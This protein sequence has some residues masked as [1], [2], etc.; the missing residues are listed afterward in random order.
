MT[1]PTLSTLLLVPA[2][3]DQMGLLRCDP[4]LG[5]R[6]PTVAICTN[7]HAAHWLAEQADPDDPDTCLRCPECG[8]LYNG[9]QTTITKALALAHNSEPVPEGCDRAERRRLCDEHAFVTHRMVRQCVTHGAAE[10]RALH[11]LLSDLGTL[12]ALDAAGRDVT[13]EVLRG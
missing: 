2:D 5:T 9:W 12:I 6:P 4:M 7:C 11:R 3:G 10:L 13:D 1:T 8:L